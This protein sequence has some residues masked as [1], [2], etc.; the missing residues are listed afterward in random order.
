M[1]A[2][3]PWLVVAGAFGVMLVGFG[4]AYSFSAFIEPLERDLAASRGDV[5]LVFSLAVF[6]YFVLGAVTGPLAGRIGARPT[7]LVGI[8]I[9]ATGFWIAGQAGSIVGVYA[10]YALGVGVGI[11][12]AYVPSIA[13]VQPW[14]T[15]NRGFASGLAVSGIGVG[16]LGGPP[17]VAWIIDAYGWRF[18]YELLA[19]GVLLFGA[20]AAMLLAG[21]PALAG[22]PRTAFGPAVRSRRFVLLYTASVL[23]SV[24]AFLPFVHLVPYAQMQGIPRA[25]AV[26]LVGAIG[27][28][29]TAGRFL[30]GGIADRLGRERSLAALYAGTG[31]AF[32]AWLL[33][34]SA[35]ALFAVAAFY[36]LC[37]G[38]YVALMP[39][40]I[41]DV[42]GA[43][44]A[45]ALI[46][47]LYTSVGVGTLFG[48]SLAGYAFDFTGSY[49]V[50]IVVSALLSFG[51]AWCVTRVTAAHP[52]P[53]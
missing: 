9:L 12:F 15:T 25:T 11:A 34:S 28:G 4:A 32:V 26:L 50:A 47:L 29:S 53:S 17:L 2:L 46:G 37:Y 1:S 44:Q 13:A 31:V 40:L 5:S 21:S 8:A 51:G 48:P 30:L 33:S 39:A 16:T 24:G 3:R 52:P 18:A 43:R 41:A 38:G 19:G 42:F 45:S 49:T 22:L 10:G 6:L 36:G 14:F 23:V 27:A 35:G 7:V 20:L